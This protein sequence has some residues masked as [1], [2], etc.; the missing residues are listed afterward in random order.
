MLRLVLARFSVLL[1]GLLFG[2][3]ATEQQIQEVPADDVSAEDLGRTPVDLKTSEMVTPEDLLFVD[4]VF[5]FYVAPEVAPTPDV[6]ITDGPDQPPEEAVEQA[7]PDIHLEGTTI[8]ELQESADSLECVVKYG[9]MLVGNDI[10]LKQVVVSAPPYPFQFGVD[11][12]H[13]YYLMDPGGGLYSGIHATYP[14]A[15]VPELIPGM[16]VTVTGDHKESSCFSIF[17]AES[18]LVNSEGPAPEPFLTTPAEIMFEPEAFEGVFV[19]VENVTVTDANPDAN[20]G[21]DHHEFVVNNSL[22]VGN[23]Y[24]LKYMTLPTDAR[25]VGDVFQHVVGVVKYSKDAFHLMPRTNADLLLEGAQPPVDGP[26]VEFVEPT[27]DVIEQPDV[28]DGAFEIMED[29]PMVPDLPVGQDLAPL[30]VAPDVPDTPDSPI[31]INEIMADPDGIPDDKG[32]WL[33]LVNAADEVVDINGWRIEDESGQLHIIM[34]GGPFL[35]Q[36]GQI[37]VLGAN[38]IESTNGGVE[39]NYQYPY[40]DF[41]IANDS[42]SIILKNLYGEEVD[43]V[44]YDKFNG[45][46]VPKGASIELLHPN[47]DNNDPASWSVAVVPYGDGSNLGTPGELP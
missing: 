23:D 45:W 26:I 35:L 24:E 46:K 32:E 41:K 15:Q 25:N 27:A 30:D 43:A 5:D 4:E 22:R 42:D 38:A 8:K 9:A 16:V 3:C 39:V 19:R 18:I 36:P 21:Y 40:S 31:V 14:S 10:T 11:E 44:H 12:L 33:E 28:V 17:Q 29:V 7:S 20:E 1:I 47:L 2:A 34:N 6:K 13:G 37:L